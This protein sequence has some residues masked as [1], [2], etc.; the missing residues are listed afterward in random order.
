MDK[1]SNKGLLIA[2]AAVGL[3]IAGDSLLRTVPWGLNVPIMGALCVGALVFLKLKIGKDRFSLREYALLAAALFFASWFAIRDSEPLLFLNAVAILLIGAMLLLPS[4]KLPIKGSGVVHYAL[5]GIAMG[6]SMALLP[7]V[8]L[9]KDLRWNNLVTSGRSQKA[10]LAVRG[11]L[12]AAP[13]VLGFGALFAAADAA[14][15]GLVANTFEVV[16]QE[17]AL[18]AFFTA[19][20]AWPAAG[21]LRALTLGA[22]IDGEARET[23]PEPEGRDFSEGGVES[24]TE[25]RSEEADNPPAFGER[26]IPSI[27]APESVDEA[28]DE[29]AKNPPA[30]ERTDRKWSP[31]ALNNSLLPDFLT[32]G[33]VEVGIVLGSLNLLFLTFVL[34]QLPYL[35]GGMDLVQNQ[36]GLKLAEY[37]RRGFGELFFASMLVLPILLALHWLI[38]REA[39]RAMSLFRYLAAI[40]IGLLFVIMMSAFQ[41]MILYT[42]A[43]GYGMTAERFFPMAFMAWLAVVFLL[44]GYTVLR[45]RRSRFAWNAAVS[46]LALVAVLNFVNPDDYIVRTNLELMRE[47]RQFDAGYNSSLSADAAPALMEAFPELNAIQQDEILY[48]MTRNRCFN[49]PFDDLRVWNFSRSRF[50]ATGF[51]REAVLNA[52]CSKFGS[53]GFD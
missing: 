20:F 11:I 2:A 42:G 14:F 21:Y 34:L 26:H 25:A 36:P 50:Q 12:I 16:P 53:V 9:T 40:Q 47:G 17:L 43:L 31:R 22:S 6:L 7:A 38:K 37:A 1:Y 39:D 35:F 10:L 51:Y 49:P 48:G 46:G 18:H 4:L 15:E 3:G 33:S 24:V 19:F 45:G 30:E 41:R 44:F 29:T 13:L 23:E 52:D 8:V 28:T 32:V 5:S 27:T